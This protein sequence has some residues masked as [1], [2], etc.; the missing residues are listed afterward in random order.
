MAVA[1]AR[2][3]A[4][5][6]YGVEEAV[7]RLWPNME[8]EGAAAHPIRDAVQWLWKVGNG[9]QFALL[10]ARLLAHFRWLAAVRVAAPV[11]KYAGLSEEQMKA[12]RELQARETGLVKAD[13]GPVRHRRRL[14]IQSIRSW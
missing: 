10:Q 14:R 13:L 2:T 5:H 3:L 4:D 12:V 1:I 9:Q 11:V 8:D 7:W 6:A